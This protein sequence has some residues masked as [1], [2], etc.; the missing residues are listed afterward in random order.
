M[1]L[2]RTDSV[3]DMF[4]TGCFKEQIVLAGIQRSDAADVLSISLLGGST[5]DLGRK[6]VGLI[7]AL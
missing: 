4:S 2:C 3:L 7:G 1:E 6:K 5:M